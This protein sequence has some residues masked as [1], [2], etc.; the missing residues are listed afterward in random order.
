MVCTTA[1]STFLVAFLLALNHSAGWILPKKELLAW[2][3]R[4]SAVSVQPSKGKYFIPAEQIEELREVVDIVSVIESFNLPQFKRNGDRATCLCPFHDDHN[5]SMNID[6]NKGIYKCFSCGAGG[7]VYNFI[8]EYSKLEGEEISFPR[9][10]QIIKENFASD[11]GPSLEFN[12]IL[13][14][15]GD[16]E[17]DRMKQAKKERLVQ[18]NLE[19]ASYF[20][21]NLVSMAGAGKARAYLRDRKLNPTTIRAFSIGYAP[22]CYFEPKGDVSRRWG[23]GSLVSY[24]RE[25]N[26]T[27]QEIFDAGLAI[28]TKANSKTTNNSAPTKQK[29]T[30]HIIARLSFKIDSV[31][32]ENVEVIHYSNIMDRFRDRIM[33]PI[34]DS[35]GKSVI[36]FGGRILDRIETKADIR[37][38][39]YI[40]SPESL[41][42]KKQEVLFGQHMAKNSVRFWASKADDENHP[43]L[44]VEGYMD[45]VALWQVG[46]RES[47]ASM[48][49]S[50]TAKQLNSVAAIA[51]RKN[52]TSLE[53]YCDHVHR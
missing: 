8:Q 44:I 47:V 38:P 40:N 17:Y 29:G 35:T 53:S 2:V 30:K 48:G 18:V 45:V 51:G 6:A 42:F 21:K 49:T 14:D 46:I 41:I 1:H 39:K 50:L 10:V 16:S 19:A 4:N 28:Q 9:A 3:G 22:D 27:A 34:F 13:N 52:G 32:K 25:Q 20:E 23:E 11:V 24:L 5:P 36:G 31:L 33:V 12:S 43:V 37:A 15:S 7:N 26:F